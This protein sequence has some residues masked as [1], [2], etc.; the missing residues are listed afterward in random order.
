VLRSSLVFVQFAI[1]IGLV[2]STLIISSQTQFARSKNLGFEKE[3]VLQLRS[4][5]DYELLES[6]ELLENELGAIPGVL[7]TAMSQYV[8]SDIHE[9]NAFFRQPGE[10]GKEPTL[11]NMLSMDFD[12]FDLYQVE[13]IH[14]RNLSPDMGGDYVEWAG[15]GEQAFA[16]AVLNETAVRNLGYSGPAEA[17]GKTVVWDFEDQSSANFE[18]VGV[19]QDFH[20]RSLHNKVRPMI[21]FRRDMM[22]STLSVRFKT[23]DLPGLLSQVDSAWTRVAPDKPIKRT[24]L[25]DNLSGLYS[26]E[27]KT[28]A[29]LMAFAFLANFIAALGLLGLSSFVV[30]RRTREI[31]IRKVLGARTR[32]IVTLMIGQFSRPVVLAN[33]IALPLSWWFMREWLGGFA[34]RIDLSPGFFVYAALTS[35]ALAWV[36]VGVYASRVARA[37]PVEALRYE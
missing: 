15:P 5:D 12:F 4:I 11:L 7:S 22:W 3:G 16:T 10:A 18:I 29:V 8:P 1:A 26:D 34:Y 31:G 28:T 25:E 32:D 36:T 2:T 37:K 6:T 27:E 30:K 13:L 24:V 21:Y 23:D 35:L 17:V 33:L 20:L 19:V 14:G 9:W